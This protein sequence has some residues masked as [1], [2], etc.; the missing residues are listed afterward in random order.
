VNDGGC[1]PTGQI[2]RGAKPFHH[3]T[4]LQPLAQA[5]DSAL[6][7]IQPLRRPRFI[8]GKQEQQHG[9]SGTLR[10]LQLELRDAFAVARRHETPTPCEQAYV[11]VATCDVGKTFVERPPG[12]RRIVLHLQDVVSQAAQR[13]ANL[14]AKG[15]EVFPSLRDVNLGHAVVACRVCDAAS[16]LAFRLRCNRGEGQGN[17]ACDGCAMQPFSAR[18]SV[19]D[20]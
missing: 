18:I 9:F 7:L 17:K 12:P 19:P 15:C 16:A 13:A 6:V 3:V 5:D 1:H 10:L 11:D 20:T 2:V 14:G 8:F 4:F